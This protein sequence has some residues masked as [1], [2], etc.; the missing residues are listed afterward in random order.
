[1]RIQ[2]FRHRRPRRAQRNLWQRLTWKQKIYYLCGGGLGLLFLYS[3]LWLPSVDD[4]AQLVFA[5]STIIYDRGALDPAKDPNDH[6]LYVIHGDENREFIPLEEISPWIK[7]ATIAIEDDNFYSWYHWGFDVGGITKGALNYFFGI[8]ERRGGSTITQQ[9]VKNTFLSRERSIIRKFNELLLSI[10]MELFYSKDEILEMYLNKIPYGHNAHGIEA[11]AKT[12][13][14]KSA[15]DLSLAESS[16]LA[17]LPVAPTRFSPYGPNKRLLMGW[18]ECDGEEITPETDN[19]ETTEEN[20]KDCDYKKGRK[21]LVLQRLLDTKEISE[22]EFRLAWSQTKSLEFTKNRTDIK[23]PHFVFYVR[24]Q[25]EE[26]YGKEFLRDGGLRI[27][28]TLDPELQTLAE[29]TIAV[30]TALHE[31][32]HE[33]TN[34]ALLA[35]DPNNGQ[36]LS[37]VGGKNYFDE[38]NDG[39][40]DVLTARRQPGSSFKPLVYTTA[41]ENGYSPST[42]LVDAETDFGGNYQPQ[43][44]D[45]EF[46]GP[47]TAR[48]SLNRSL[49]IP[50]IK[51]AYL[52]TP[53]QIFENA[54]KIGIKI[55]GTPDQHGV[56]IG[57]G[58]A[59]VEPLSHINS[60]QVFAG[61]GSYFEPSSILEIRNSNGKNVRKN[62]ILHE[63]KKKDWMLK[64]L[65]SPA[66]F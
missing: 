11:A 65:D 50:A 30:K 20:G 63:L 24:Q 55:E 27:Y 60:F 51:M 46:M 14:G 25:L 23:A 32:E 31:R 15:R 54:Q 66:I 49:N 29:E 56:A 40:F 59:E 16:I 9:L 47:V 34:A 41:F 1:M 33:A 42:L 38:E 64:L 39:Q 21:D 19:E 8:G 2:T 44:F 61:D 37:Y 4:A 5:E 6:I 52:A 18:E 53:K 10:K 17:S 36:I 12:F 3:W 7:K 58:V 22:D 43:N 28:T 48:E 45:G 13:F 35:V 62:L 26:K 57:I